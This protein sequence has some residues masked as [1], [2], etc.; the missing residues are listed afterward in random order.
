ME[1]L[2]QVVKNIRFL[3]FF[4]TYIRRPGF[5]ITEKE[6]VV[7]LQKSDRI[8]N[9]CITKRGKVSLAPSLLRDLSKPYGTTTK[10]NEA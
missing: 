9:F 10:S 8:S 4:L 3:W 5:T 2:M 1:N 7:C 6:A